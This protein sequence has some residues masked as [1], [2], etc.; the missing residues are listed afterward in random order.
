MTGAMTW[1]LS[2]ARPFLLLHALVG[3]AALAVSVHVLHFA[4]RGG[5]EGNAAFRAK[6]RRYARVTWPVYLATMLTGIL[7]YPAYKV[8][9]RDAW[10]DAHAPAM[11]GLFEI[12][13]HWAA[14]GMILTWAAWRYYCRP[15]VDEV[16]HPNRAFW[17][18]HGILALLGALCTAFSVIVGLWL[19]MV[20]S[21]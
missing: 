4:I 10:L 15:P 9:V 2:I 17:K 19:V 16:I 3:C 14:L 6:A 12:K 1:E 18:G 13:E 11:T 7:I 20:R 21:L 8:T 5:Q